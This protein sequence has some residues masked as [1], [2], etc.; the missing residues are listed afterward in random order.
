MKELVLTTL[1]ILA[2]FE[3]AARPSQAQMEE[4]RSAMDSCAA[5]LGISKPER[6]QRPSDADREKMDQCLAEKGIEKPSHP[7]RGGGRPPER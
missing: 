3:V 1:L 6:G 4:M 7:P 2:S 5:E